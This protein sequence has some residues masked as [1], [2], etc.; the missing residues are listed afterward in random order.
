[1]DWKYI[2]WNEKQVGDCR[3][4]GQWSWRPRNTSLNTAWIFKKILKREKEGELLGDLW[5]HIKQS[6]CGIWAPEGE[7]RQMEIENKH[8][9]GRFK[10]KHTG[11]TLTVNGLNAPIKWRDDHF[12]SQD[13]VL[14]CL[15]E[16]HFQYKD[17][18]SSR[19]GSVETN[20]IS[21]WNQLPR[22]VFFKN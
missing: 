21:L 11:N 22:L 3:R 19:H 12:W 4:K 6:N 2:R 8:H 7:G 5:N 17:S 14:C 10:F 9:Y 20:L 1:M 15:Q 18:G 13:W 16:V